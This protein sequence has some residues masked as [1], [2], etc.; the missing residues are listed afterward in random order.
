MAGLFDY[1]FQL[2]EIKKHKPPLQKLNEIIDWELFRKP[3]EEALT[4][5]DKKSNAGRKPYDKLLMFKI[6]ILQRYYN[7]SDEQTEFQIKDRLSFLDFLGLQ[8]GDNVPDEK[9]IWLFKEQLKE[10]NLAKT[11]FDI[12][13]AKLVS[14][15]VVAKEGTLVDA[16]FIKVPKQRN[17]RDENSD[18]K[19]GAVPLEFGKSKNKL[20]QKDCDARW[21]TKYKTKE[22]GYKDH[23]SVDQKT[24]VITNYTVTPSSTHDSQAIKDLINEDDNA[25]Y[26]DSAYKS[27]EIEDYL[28]ENN[29][30]SKIINRAYRNK[31]LSNKQHKQ[32]HKHSKT[33]VRVEHIFGTL[34]TSMNNALSLKAIGL[35][36]IKS[37]TGLLNLTYNL[38]RYEQLARLKKIPIMI[39]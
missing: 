29:V 5:D 9:T 35:Q 12:F 20:S 3:I 21:V 22:F 38:L 4:K 34:K 15:G 16:S 28:K 11:L 32:N 23:I 27:K 6:L 10:K 8:I 18:I 39:S 1:E 30:K 36:R 26:A 19:K 33:R 24:K 31:S 2:N 14:N 17:K 37:L 7:L 13:T 25:L